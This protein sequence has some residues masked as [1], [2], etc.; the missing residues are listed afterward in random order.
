MVLECIVHIYHFSNDSSA[1]TSNLC[2]YNK[3]NY[4]QNVVVYDECRDLKYVIVTELFVLFVDGMIV[5]MFCV[6]CTVYIL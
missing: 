2:K 1:F 3:K 4:R 6:V 5:I